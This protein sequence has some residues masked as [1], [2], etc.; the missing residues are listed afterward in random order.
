[1]CLLQ[2]NSQAQCST[3]P[4]PAPTGAGTG[5]YP[6]WCCTGAPP[7]RC[8]NNTSKSSCTSTSLSWDKLG[9][10]A[11]LALPFDAAARGRRAKGWWTTV[12][13][14]SRVVRRC[15]MSLRDGSGGMKSDLGTRSI[16]RRSRSI[17]RRLRLA[18][19]TSVFWSVSR[20]CYTERIRQV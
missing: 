11:L 18:S 4:T 13:K 14:I 20:S 3:V 9:T 17:R 8:A 15:G 1:M 12:F 2:P 10:T 7:R 16:A 6:F 5:E 19:V